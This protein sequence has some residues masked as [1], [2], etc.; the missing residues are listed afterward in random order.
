MSYPFSM[1][2]KTKVILIGIDGLMIQR[3]ID[4][5][6]AK[7]LSDLRKNSFFTE[8]LVDLPTVSGPSWT[9]LLTGQTQ[10]V[11]KV[12][13][14][15]FQNHNLAEAPDLLTQAAA[16]FSEVITY[17]AAGWPP[18]ID[19]QD[20]G[21]VIASRVEDQASGN[22]YIFVRDGETHGYETID[23]EVAQH[24]V[25]IIKEV[26]PD[27]SFVYF[28]GADEA[29]HNSGTVEGSY[30]DAIERIDLLV[31]DLYQSILSRNKESAEKW[32]L[33]ITTD[34]GHRDEGGHGGDSAQER[35]SFVIAHGIGTENPS[36][37]LDIK[38]EHLVG[39]ILATL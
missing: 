35:A 29:G 5:G 20:V 4:S 39:H 16:N 6:R 13:D 3:A 10:E 19:P 1:A 38:P 30:F 32:L 21:P 33:V 15:D 26:G 25:Q 28:C 36:W 11:H 34:H 12:V 14:N 8:M 7:T 31:E 24:A 23:P 17:A 27:I 37:P 9:T 18:L 2:S 22:H